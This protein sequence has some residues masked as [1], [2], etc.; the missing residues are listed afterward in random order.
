MAERLDEASLQVTLVIRGISSSPAA[1]GYCL[2]HIPW[3]VRTEQ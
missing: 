1:E 3:M 2:E